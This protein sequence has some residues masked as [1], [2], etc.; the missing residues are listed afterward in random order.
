M[1]KIMDVNQAEEILK[2]LGDAKRLQIL[3]LIMQGT[4]CNCD[5][6]DSLKIQPNL[7]S[8]HL[9]ILKEAGLILVEKD[10]LDSRWKYYSV[11]PESFEILQSFFS[12]FF[13]INRIQPRQ[14]TCGPQNILTLITDHSS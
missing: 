14:A 10:P 4:Q 2:A 3:D 11:N 5:F 13:N 9:R 8:H 12:E 1:K 6:C 7:V